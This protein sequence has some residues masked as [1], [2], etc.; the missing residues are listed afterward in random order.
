MVRAQINL[1]PETY[2]KIAALA[3]RLGYVQKGGPRSGQGS[4]VKLLG[5]VARGE[6]AVSG[7]EKRKAAYIP[8]YG[9]TRPCQC[10]H[11]Y[12]CHFDPHE[13]WE[14]VGCKYCECGEFKD[15]ANAK[16]RLY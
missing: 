13:N 10:G 1:D 8:D 14:H 5:A 12:E 7:Q 3:A 15:Q 11:T 6:V 2:T 4:P 16:L 9:A